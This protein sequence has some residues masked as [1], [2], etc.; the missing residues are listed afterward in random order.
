MTNMKTHFKNLVLHNLRRGPGEVNWTPPALGFGNHLYMWLHAW[1]R[2]QSGV[3]SRVLYDESMASWLNSF[4]ELRPLTVQRENVRL[5]DKRF[6]LWGQRFGDDFA[7]DALAAFAQAC[8][9]ESGPMQ[10]ALDRARA[11]LDS[12]VLVVNVRRGDYYSVPKFFDRYGMNIEEYVAFAVK[13][14]ARNRGFTRIRVIS[15]DPQ[16][17]QLNLPSLARLAPIDFGPG[18]HGP[19]EDLATLAAAESLVLANSTFSYWGAYLNNVVHSGGHDR[20]WAPRFHA[21]HLNGGHAWQLD[22]RWN[23]IEQVPGG[24][25]PPGLERSNTVTRE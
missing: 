6:I 19:L 7:P 20:V 24:W 8:L 25:D 23:V 10:Q 16:W 21:R 11:V 2:Q 12:E 13:G 3:T 14:V 5:T 15:D 1:M 18:K 22:P 9:L 17:C 4:P